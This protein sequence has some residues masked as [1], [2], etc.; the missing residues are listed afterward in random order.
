MLLV[1]L[2]QNLVVDVCEC[3]RRSKPGRENHK[4]LRQEIERCASEG[5]AVFPYSE[6]HL[7]ESANVTDPESREE[8]I[9]FWNSVSFGYRFHD[10][11]AM[12]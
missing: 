10:G 9:R 6:V 7:A 5:I 12:L 1:Y 11:T 4:L 3:M 8:Q 2:D